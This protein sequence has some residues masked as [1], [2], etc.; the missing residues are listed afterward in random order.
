MTPSEFAGTGLLMFGACLFA[1]LVFW[2]VLR[3]GR[4]GK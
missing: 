3:S 2:I 4:H 1:L